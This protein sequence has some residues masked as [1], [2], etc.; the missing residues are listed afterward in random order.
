MTRLRDDLRGLLVV[1]VL[2]AGP[3]I[4]IAIAVNVDFPEPP[5]SSGSTYESCHGGHRLD[6]GDCE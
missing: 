3:I 2:V 4:G 5:P 6:P 1:L